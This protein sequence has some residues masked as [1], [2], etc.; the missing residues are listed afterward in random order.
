MK[1]H[2][3]FAKFLNPAWWPARSKIRVPG[4]DLVDRVNFYLKKISKRYRFS[5]KNKVNGLQPGF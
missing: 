5:K 1:F 3:L 4:F 2:K